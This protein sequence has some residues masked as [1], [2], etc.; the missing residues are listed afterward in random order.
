MKRNE[1]DILKSLQELRED[2]SENLEELLGFGGNKEEKLAKQAEKKGAEMIYGMASDMV[3][4]DNPYFRTIAIRAGKSSGSGSEDVAKSGILTLMNALGKKPADIETYKIAND[5]GFLKFIDGTEVALGWDELP[6]NKAILGDLKAHWAAQGKEG[7]I[8]ITYDVDTPE[9]KGKRAEAQKQSENAMLQKVQS[10][11]FQKI[12]KIEL[13]DGGLNIAANVKR[14]IGGQI[15]QSGKVIWEIDI[16]R[17]GEK[18][19]VAVKKACDAV[20]SIFEKVAALYNKVYG[21]SLKSGAGVW[22]SFYREEK[23]KEARSLSQAEYEKRM[24]QAVSSMGM[25]GT[26][27]AG[28]S[29]DLVLNAKAVIA[30]AIAN[31][32]VWDGVESMSNWSKNISNLGDP[33]STFAH[34]FYYLTATKQTTLNNVYVAVSDDAR[35]LVG[36]QTQ[37]ESKR[38]GNAQMLWENVDAMK[39]GVYLNIS[40]KERAMLTEKSESKSQ[41]RFMGMVYAY[42]NGELD[43]KNMSKSMLEK[44]KKAAEGMTKKEAEKFASTKHKGIPEKVKKEER[45]LS[46]IDTLKEE[47]RKNSRL[48]MSEAYKSREEQIDDLKPIRGE[49]KYVEYDEEYE[50]WGVFGSESGFCY[51]LY[52]SKGQAEDKLEQLEE[53]VQVK[54]TTLKECVIS[55]IPESLQRGL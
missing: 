3:S 34:L 20:D 29:N 9:N 45:I 44:V 36:Q 51:G 52:G 11:G 6:T 21:T 26:S 18:T 37:Q 19:Q 5:A 48:V 38:W 17:S 7:D 24:Q 40:F 43:T 22:D 12:E 31:D 50:G 53:S 33:I 49:E 2:V 25:G 35:I 30:G 8:A 42:K 16:Y 47:M 41:Q 23:A 15:Q 46:D 4:K 28:I 32:L 55:Y 14:A 10:L 13:N 1:E 39:R 54:K 27:S